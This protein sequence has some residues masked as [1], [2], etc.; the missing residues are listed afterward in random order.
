MKAT[1]K[2]SLRLVLGLVVIM[3]LTTAS[4]QTPPKEET[5]YF[6]ATH[7]HND[8]YQPRPLTDALESGMG[9]VEPDV[10]YLEIPFVDDQGN[11]RVM[12]ELYVAHDWEEIEGNAQNWRTLGTLSEM[13][14]EPLWELYH[15]RGGTIYPQGTLLLH[16]DM[17]TDTEKTWRLLQSILQ[18]YPGLV[19]RY[20]LKSRTVI[21]GPVTVYTNAE[22]DAE[23]L[24]EYEVINSTV[25][26][27]F[28]NIFESE[29][30]ESPVYVETQ[31]RMPIVSSNLRAY[32]DL[33][34]FFEFQV[35]HEEIVRE[36]GDDYPELT[37]E[38]LIDQLKENNWSLANALMRDGKI[39]V[40]DYLV[41][42]MAEANRLGETHGHL[43]RFWAAPDE[44]W[45]WDIVTP[46]EH[47]VLATDKPREASTYLQG[48]ETAR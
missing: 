2:K 4:A 22:P 37:E 40:A 21:P 1:G 18:A 44:A 48:D 39:T 5:P 20:D 33:H 17:K 3:L 25:D 28:G 34:Q 32:N 13:Y 47:V 12:K 38:N 24:A 31:W 29:A 16:V 41:E 30:W 6:E 10:Y 9:G 27:R 42:Q 8:Y 14:L 19:T 23:V 15:Q 7:S 45:F 11:S 36:Y 46:L 43:M 26:G 35:P